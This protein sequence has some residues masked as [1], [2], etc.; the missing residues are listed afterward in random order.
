MAKKRGRPKKKPSFEDC[1]EIIENEIR[2]RRAKWKL[3]SLSWL[4]YD[5][6]SQILRIH[7]NKKWHLYKA[8]KP[9]EPWLNRII[10]N[11]I[12]NLIRNNYT[13][14]S[15]P[16][17]KCAAYEG[18]DLCFLFGK[19]SKDCKVY[20]NWFFTRRDRHNVKMTLPIDHHLNEVKQ[21]ENASN[22]NIEDLVKKF[23]SAIIKELRP[24]E[25][26][27]YILLYVEN[28][29]EEE[30]AKLMGYKTSEKDRKPG[31]KQIKNIQKKIIEK[32]R[33]II[34]SG[35]FDL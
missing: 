1:I 12:K 34:D 28:K 20:A 33:K 9:L 29:D 27:A 15:K 18:N 19:V 3:Q 2:K 23:H 26:K 25:K 6:V 35:S 14:F 4:D 5:D 17:L 8:D 10:S 13:N 32:A 11:Q 7:I 30:A 24:V 16:C 21:K 31:Y 22:Y